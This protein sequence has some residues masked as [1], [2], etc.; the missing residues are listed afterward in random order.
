ML[1]EELIK[2]LVNR[3]YQY[4]AIYNLNN[5]FAEEQGGWNTVFADTNLKNHTMKDIARPNNDT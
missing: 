1:T 2:N 3:S 4:V 5:K